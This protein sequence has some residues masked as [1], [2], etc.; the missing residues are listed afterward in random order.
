VI[1]SDGT[2]SSRIQGAFSKAEL[3]AA[4]DKVS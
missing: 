3:D 4:L 1:N 2:I